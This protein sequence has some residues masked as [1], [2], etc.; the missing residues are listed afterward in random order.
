[1]GLSII[2][3]VVQDG[4]EESFVV[5]MIHLGFQEDT[6]DMDGE[7]FDHGVRQIGHVVQV[8]VVRQV[9]VCAGLELDFHFKK[10]SVRIKERIG[11]WDQKFHGIDAR[12]HRS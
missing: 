11:G 10:T 3:V 6:I 1:M 9:G 2:S 7:L 4:L 8:R 12:G 5:I